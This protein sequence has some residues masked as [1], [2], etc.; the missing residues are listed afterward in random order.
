MTSA[1]AGQAA[2]AAIGHGVAAPGSHAG[3]PCDSCHFVD[4]ALDGLR[5]EITRRG[6]PT[7]DGLH[8]GPCEIHKRHSYTI[9][10][11][12]NLYACPG[13]AGESAMATGHIAHS[14]AR[15]P[16]GTA[17]ECVEAWKQCGDCSFIP[18]CA[19]GCTVAA[20]HELGDM[21]APACHK[22]S[23]QTALV[24]HAHDVAA[25]QEGTAS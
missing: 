1:G 25:R 18:V 7:P 8:M 2:S 24:A 22:T 10:P 4:E 6:F 5:R 14:A 20:H 11:L 16:A 12:G 23:L 21:H 17:F 19:G 13:F 3:S 15:P 9:G